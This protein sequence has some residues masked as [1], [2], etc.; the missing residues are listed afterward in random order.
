MI[1]PRIRLTRRAGHPLPD[2]PWFYSYAHADQPHA[3]RLREALN[4]GL[5]ASG[6]YSF[7]CWNDE[8][9]LVGEHWRAQIDR[10]VQSCALGVLAISRSFLTSDFIQHHELGQLLLRA[11]AGGCRVIPVLL[12]QVTFGQDNLLGL[13]ELQIYR[14][15]DKKSFAERGR[16]Q[17]AWA[18]GLDAQIHEVLRRYGDIH[19]SDGA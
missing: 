13:E 10:A 9:L 14:D 1:E 16:R 8:Q 12:E 6:S 7:S 5:R 18:R 17:E 19:E 15:A 2:V 11:Q 4:R 3:G